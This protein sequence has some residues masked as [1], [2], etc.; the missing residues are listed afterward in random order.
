MLMLI[1]DISSIESSNRDQKE[2]DVISLRKFFFPT[3][4]TPQDECIGQYRVYLHCLM[5]DE[6]DIEVWILENYNGQVLKHSI[7]LK[8]LMSS[9]HLVPPMVVAVSRF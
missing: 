2:V 4:E 7:C 6:N 3:V 5:E 9:M 8:A 1:K